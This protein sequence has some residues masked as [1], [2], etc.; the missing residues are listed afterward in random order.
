MGKLPSIHDCVGSSEW[1]AVVPIYRGGPGYA[2]H[3]D[4]DGDGKACESC[5]GVQQ[6]RHEPSCKLTGPGLVKVEACLW[7]AGIGVGGREASN[8]KGFRRGYWLIQLSILLPCSATRLGLAA[9]QLHPPPFLVS[10]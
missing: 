5:R 9:C 2:S 6:R 3:Q 1:L 8:R 7:N 10:A 4:R